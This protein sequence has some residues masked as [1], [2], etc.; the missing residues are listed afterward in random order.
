VKHRLQVITHLHLGPMRAGGIFHIC[1]KVEVRQNRQSGAFHGE[2]HALLGP[3][4][5]VED[6]R[7]EVV[8]EAMLDIRMNADAVEIDRGNGWLQLRLNL[9][10]RRPHMMQRVGGEVGGAHRSF[11]LRC[12]VQI[13]S[14]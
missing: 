9:R 7:V 3:P 14:V 1:S 13:S 5:P 12:N 8:E 11:Q 2:V 6:E 4:V 10:Q